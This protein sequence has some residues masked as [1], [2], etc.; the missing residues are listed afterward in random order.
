LSGR[1]NLATDAA[2]DEHPVAMVRS[3]ARALLTLLPLLAAGCA[4]V[5]VPLADAERAL[6]TAEAQVQGEQWDDALAALEP[7]ALE[8]CPKRLRDRRDVAQARAL[9]GNGEAWEAYLVLERFPDDH[10]H[11][12]LR[13]TVVAMLWDI[14]SA[15]SA[16]DRGFLFFWSDRR[17]GRTVLEHLVTRHPDTTR[18]ADALRIL[19]D[20][21]FV[22]ENYE[23]A[24]ARFRDL[25]LNRPESEWF[26]YAQ[27]RFAMS[28]V[29]SLQGSEYDLDRMNHAT[30]ELRDFLAGR[31]E[32]PAI[33][34]EAEAALAQ[35]QEWQVER[36]LQIAAFYERVGNPVGRRHH[37]E[38][39][40]GSEFAS[41]AGH[42]AAVEALEALGPA[43]TGA[44]SG[45]QNP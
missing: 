41:T 4:T 29:A 40:A 25:M 33:V 32:N 16:S 39:A 17:A 18:L 23:L 31:P 14:G 42:A 22:D 1:K 20:M 28:I 7:L 36:H 15:L 9:V 30:R 45:G 38:I 3:A 37:I 13:P 35:V 27:Y 6:A 12:D 5:A 19:G 44:G 24:Q 11:S 10:P 34:A 21:A 43:P 26:V 8:A 2:A